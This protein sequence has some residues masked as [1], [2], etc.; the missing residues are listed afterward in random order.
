MIAPS[1][2]EIRNRKRR[3]APSCS[4]SFTAAEM[5]R[6]L[7][8]SPQNARTLLKGIPA[9]DWIW[10]S[11]VKTRAWSFDSLPS[12]LIARLATLASRHGFATPLQFLQNGPRPQR[13]LSIAEVSD[14]DTERA[15]KLRRALARCLS[16]PAETS[17]A[18]LARIAAPDYFR[19]LGKVSDRQLRTIITR[20]IKRDGGARK[21]DRPN[22]YLSERTSKRK[23]KA[24]PLAARFRF[25][26][27]DQ[28]FAIL[29]DPTRP[30]ISE[31]SYCWREVVKFW[32][33]RVMEGAD[34]IKL[35]Q[36]LREYILGSAPF[37]GPT[38]QAV[39]TALNR[40]ILRAIKEG[41]DSIVDG[42]L[43]PTRPT[44]KPSDFDAM[45]KLLAQHVI[46]HCGR[47][48]SQAYR[49]LHGGTAHNG[50]RF[51]E[52][53]RAAYTFDVRGAKSRVPNCV[54]NAVRPIV[55][56]TK[57]IHL[58]PR[59]ARLARPSIR[60]DWSAVLAGASYTSDD[61]T[62][63]HYVYDWHEKGEYE[64]SGRRF[65]VIRP[66][67][68]PVVDERTGNPLGFSLTPAPTYNSW[69]IR[70]LIT[71]ICM[72]PEIGLPF[73][74]FLFERGIWTSRNV[75]ALSEWAA[76]DESFE[77]H[78]IRL[79][80]KH[81]TT[82]KAKVIEQAIGTLQ[83]L[84]EFSP[85]YIG[86]GEQRVKHERVQSFLQK[87]RR[88]GQP[89]KAELNPAEMLM[90]HEQC[91]EMLDGVL[92]RFANES[93]NGE[94]LDGLSPAKGWAQLSGGRA[95]VVLPETLRFLLATA[96]S[97]QTVTQEGIALRIG[98]QK[99]WYCGSVRLGQLIGEKVRVRFNPELPEQIVVSHIA[100]DPHGLH[101]F[102]VPRF[103]RLPAHNA[104]RDEFSRAREHQDRFSSYGR[105]IYRELIPAAALTH[106]RSETGSPEL[107]AAGEANNR[108]ER[109][110]GALNNERGSQR[111]EIRRLAAS[112]R[113]KINPERVRRPSRVAGHLRRAAE[114][115][116]K[117]AASE[118]SEV[119]Q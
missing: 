97:V 89:V 1:R 64:F 113:L 43:Q 53:F 17:I 103:D 95:H 38:A 109:E 19:E 26:E 4:N 115:E 63:N 111:G 94:R 66:Q 114:L 44:V 107:R 15:H 32:D 2:V 69:Q 36:E 90:S 105:T 42:R 31:K 9:A 13:L 11:G 78:G 50:D 117:I 70:T 80:V 98:R 99:H 116:A 61:V 81:A 100:S 86:R 60:R 58:G 35:K 82:P 23:A 6:C 40:K 8:T 65:N 92:R 59:A 47:R 25:D 54:R 106:C 104:S 18:E 51:S 118:Q 71:R 29:R 45:I 41:I 101:P 5:A 88:V 30:T 67:F 48:E 12:P 110:C 102:A 62:L 56:A 46:F 27:L 24:S 91:A 39:K 20:T 68:L 16:S 85:G 87:L 93:Q 112:Q 77:R 49:Q 22:L 79:A 52:E 57:A 96:E 34:E 14:A 73:E 108:L 7:A 119:S 33:A 72:R 84:D 55:A 83:N 21:F 74:R 3:L 37:L 10:V 75:K 76:I 28:A